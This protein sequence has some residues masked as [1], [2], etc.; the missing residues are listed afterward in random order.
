[1]VTESIQT[2]ASKERKLNCKVS[3][4]R[5][6]EC[7]VCQDI[8][9]YSTNFIKNQEREG[10]DLITIIMIM[11]FADDTEREVFLTAVKTATQCHAGCGS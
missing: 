5:R 1:M 4:W 10:E 7:S 6:L 3:G 11:A 2:K 9:R 8:Q